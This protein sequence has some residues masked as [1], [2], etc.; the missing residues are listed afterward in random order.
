MGSASDTLTDEWDLQSTYVNY[1]S[2]LPGGK[3]AIVV[4]TGGHHCSPAGVSGV[5]KVA[6]QCPCVAWELCHC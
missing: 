1:C 4:A 5:G 3:T 6:Q 2:D